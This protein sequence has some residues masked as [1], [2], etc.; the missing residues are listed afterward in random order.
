MLALSSLKSP[1]F[2]KE[3]WGGL[4]TPMSPEAEAT[5]ARAAESSQPALPEPAREESQPLPQTQTAPQ[6]DD[7]STKLAAVGL[8]SNEANS[9]L[10]MYGIDPRGTNASE[11]AEDAAGRPWEEQVQ[12]AYTALAKQRGIPVGDDGER[13]HD[14]D[15]A[16]DAR[17]A[18]E[19]V[20]SHFHS[21][22]DE[23]GTT[24]EQH[25]EI[26]ED[27]IARPK[28][29]RASNRLA[30][31]GT[32]TAAQNF[33][34]FLDRLGTRVAME[35]QGQDVLDR[36]EEAGESPRYVSDK[37]WNDTYFKLPAQAQQRFTRM[38]KNV[39]GFEPGDTI[40]VRP[41]KSGIVAQ[42]WAD[43]AKGSLPEKVEHLEGPE[44]GLTA[45]MKEANDRVSGST[46]RNAGQA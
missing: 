16:R 17:N 35:S 5:S 32:D 20:I 31:E 46:N 9:I 39:S 2:L 22:T 24:P 33:G 18:V 15:T 37:F 36:M 42:D 27:P 41:D 45:L 10:G 30:S 4:R 14:K 26:P 1:L 43:V 23:T 19:Q 34:N 12:N 29:Q 11:G 44:R 21:G 25:T 13:F 3:K 38:L 7:L 28:I 8:H 6:G 40:A